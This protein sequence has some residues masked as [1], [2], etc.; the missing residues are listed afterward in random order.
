MKKNYF[1]R[2]VIPTLLAT[3]YTIPALAGPNGPQGM[4]P[5]PESTSPD[6]SLA[7]EAVR[8]EVIQLVRHGETDA[9]SLNIAGQ[10]GTHFRVNFSAT[11][12]GD[13]YALVPGGEGVIGENGMGSFSFELKKLGKEDVYLKVITS[14]TPDFSA[15]RVT[16]KPMI[17]QVEP[18][19]I[20]DRGLGTK[21]PPSQSSTLA[22]AGVKG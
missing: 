18:F 14:D 8:Q 3:V 16:P 15:T 7:T 20:K 10:P 21:E 5:S 1:A 4:P 6:V 19:Q 11:G 9:I 12:K 13:S 22:V 2:T 17:L